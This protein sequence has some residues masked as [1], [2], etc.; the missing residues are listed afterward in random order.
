M[1]SEDSGDLGA[2][3]PF[4]RGGEYGRCSRASV[5]QS[6]EKG[7][8]QDVVAGSGI[9]GAFSDR[10]H[11]AALAMVG[12]GDPLDLGRVGHDVGEPLLPVFVD[13][14]DWEPLEVF[15]RAYGRTNHRGWH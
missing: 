9:G 12:A 14:R 6:L 4:P 1:V 3:E 10:D 15:D 13:G 8:A 7:V 11:V 2:E 5:G